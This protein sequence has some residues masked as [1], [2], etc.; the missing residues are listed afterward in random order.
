MSGINDFINTVGGGVAGSIGNQIGYGIGQMTGYNDA[1]DDRQ[2]KQQ[3][4]LTNLQY[5][6]NYDLMK[7]SYEEQKNLWDS[8]NME[9]QIAHMKKAGL[10][11]G[12][13]YA[14]GGTGGSTGGGSASV[15]GGQAPNSAQ[16]KNADTSQLMAGMGMMK[17][18]SEIK[19]NEAQANKLNADAKT[20]EES[21]S[22]L[23][24]KLYEEGKG[25]YL[26]NAQEQYKM[27]AERGK[28]GNVSWNDEN[29]VKYGETQIKGN[30]IFVEELSTSI[31]QTLAN[32]GN[33]QAQALLTNEKAKGYWQELLNDTARADNDKIKATATKLAAEWTTGEFTNWKTWAELARGVTH[34]LLLFTK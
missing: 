13:M 1:L 6:A 17:L 9:A 30:S 11:P 14:K 31:A 15:G 23:I 27:L 7:A 18:Q 10:N 26:K 5:A 8:T 22:N 12:L 29:Y 24:A 34:D 2:Y 20:T 28:T 3:Q 21:R 16:L 33:Q 19:L 32:T 25:N 4:R